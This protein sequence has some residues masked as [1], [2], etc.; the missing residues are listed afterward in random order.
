M[1]TRLASRLA[2]TA[3]KGRA[4]QAVPGPQAVMMR[5][6]WLL[7]V[8]LALAPALVEADTRSAQ[9]LVSADVAPGTSIEAA[10]TPHAIVLTDADLALGYKD[11]SARY[12]VSS[13]AARGYMLHFASRAGLTRAIEVRGLGAPVEVGM[14]GATVPQFGRLLHAAEIRLQYRLHLAEDARPG[15]YEL[16]V[17]VSASPL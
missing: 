10:G 16:P 3:P 17:A 13:N 9:M 8:L 14:L 12:R 15:E 6:P 4:A 11:V 7:L 1:A 2:C 5:S